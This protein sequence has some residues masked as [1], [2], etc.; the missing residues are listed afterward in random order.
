[1]NINIKTILPGVKIPKYAHSNDACFDVR[2]C[3]SD[4]AVP[5]KPVMGELVEDQ[6]Y[7]TASMTVPHEVFYSAII[8]PGQSRIFHTGL[9]FELPDGW[10]LRGHVRS[11]VGIKR[12]LTLANGTS[13]IDAGY[14]GEVFVALHNTTDHTI[15]I[16]DGE[17]VAQF[18]LCPVHQAEFVQVN[19]VND[20]TRGNGGIGSTGVN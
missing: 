4:K 20:T 19:E 12:G 11:S 1:M 10:M 7:A 16:A 9:V 15:D 13:I 5:K 18:E 6:V 3:I 17:R 8:P 14:R 2:V